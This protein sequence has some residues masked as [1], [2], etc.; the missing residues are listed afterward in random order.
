MIG[1]YLKLALRVLGRNKLYTFISLFGI[2][3]TLA[4]LMLATSYLDVEYGANAPLSKMDNIHVLTGAQLVQW[5]R[6][7][8]TKIDSSEVDGLMTYDTTTTEKIQRMKLGPDMRTSSSSNSRI[9]YDFIKEHLLDVENKVV[10]SAYNVESSIDV[11][12]KNKKLTFS[13]AYTDADYFKI[14]DFEFLEGKPYDANAVENQARVIVINDKMAREY[15]GEL[16]SYL[17]QNVRFNQ[18]NYEVI[19]VTKEVFTSVTMVSNSAMTPLT[20]LS[21]SNMTYRKGEPLGSLQM[22]YLVNGDQQ[23][24]KLKTELRNIELNADIGDR[25]DDL[26]LRDE[27]IHEFSARGIVQEQYKDNTSI[28][29]TIIGVGL[30]LFTLIPILNLIN[31]NI[32]RIMERSA[33]IGVRKSFGAKT[34]DLIVQFVFENLILTII[35]GILGLLL[36]MGM[37]Y[38]LNSSG[39]MGRTHLSVNSSFFLVS[40]LITLIFGILSGLFPAWKVSKTSIAQALKTNSI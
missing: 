17:G 35:G 3:F 6:E 21:A 29:F 23:R 4:I 1:N 5:P 16:S 40:V 15:F 33:E 39:I 32:T 27:H 13:I 8:I 22:A 12:P 38:I 20:H 36:A 37:M 9:A 10:A 28:L 31:L 18:E 26:F 11:F 19:G 24:E 25:F 7:T 30:F 2:S 34:W 14:Y